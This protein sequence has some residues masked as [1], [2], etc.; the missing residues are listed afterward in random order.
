MSKKPLDISESARRANA[1][2]D[3]S[4]FD[5]HRRTRHHGLFQIIERLKLAHTG[6]VN[7]KRFNR[8]YRV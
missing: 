1:D 3:G 4:L 8:E 5:H 7:G 6:R 2:E